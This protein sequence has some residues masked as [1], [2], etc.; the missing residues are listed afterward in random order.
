[1]PEIKIDVSHFA[2]LAYEL[3]RIRKSPP[4]TVGDAMHRYATAIDRAARSEVDPA[5]VILVGE[6][7]WI[8]LRPEEEPAPEAIGAQ[9]DELWKMLPGEPPGPAPAATEGSV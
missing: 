2:T 4:K 9:L 8:A 6:L 5:L 3:R 7:I 1:M